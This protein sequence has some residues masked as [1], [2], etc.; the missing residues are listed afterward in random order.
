MSRPRIAIILPIRF[1][2]RAFL[3]T[4]ILQRLS[5]QAELLLVSPYADSA[6]FQ[7]TFGG[8]GIRH[9]LLLDYAPL[10]M[11]A[12]WNRLLI[13]AS[14]A[15][16]GM[17][18]LKCVQALSRYSARERGKV[19]DGLSYSAKRI[20]LP[21][22]AGI[23]PGI[24][25]LAWLERRSYSKARYPQHD[26]Y[27]EL[28]SAFK[29]DLVI[30]TSPNRPTEPPVARAAEQLGVPHLAYVL[31][32]D[33]ICCY[34]DYP[35][36]YDQYLVWNERNRREI[37]QRYPSVSPDQVEICG[38]LQFDFYALRDRFLTSRNEWAQTL[39][40][41]PKKKFIVFSESGRPVG[42]HEPELVSDLQ[43]QILNSSLRSSCVLV[44]RL[45]PMHPPAR[46]EPVRKC[47]P[48]LVVQEPTSQRD[49]ETGF[50]ETDGVTWTDDDFSR[51]INTL[52]HGDVH[53]NVS[54]T[55]TLDAAYFDRPAI[56]LDY[57]PRPGAPF[58]ELS[59]MLYRREHY[60]DIVAS[61][62]APL[63]ASGVEAIE[64]IG[65]F[66]DNPGLLAQ[67]RKRMLGAYDPFRDG[68]ASERVSNAILGFLPRSR[69]TPVQ[70]DRPLTTFAHRRPTPPTCSQIR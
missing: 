47:F 14:Y 44:V 23:F 32:F 70:T 38:P 9:A 20:L 69:V 64:W 31:S 28:L 50:T 66:L 39:G 33:N 36:I 12:R 68:R 60:L 24:P 61:G 62:G 27:L 25:G 59:S 52:H 48:E 43:Q 63:A 11:H 40:Q 16:P 30:S 6:I 37:L 51:L 8:P 22:A 17:A 56:C 18:A 2:C 19:A 29:P 15:R 4:S 49:K 5:A 34:P 53:L 67:E 45:H 26:Y 7:Q 54:S 13:D 3:S 46:W 55:M 42:P 35:R 41:N 57:D 10:G 1:A 65:R 21:R 58:R